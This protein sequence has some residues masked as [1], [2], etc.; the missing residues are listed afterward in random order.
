VPSTIDPYALIH[1][2][3]RHQLTTTLDRLASTDW[4]DPAARASALDDLDA[5]LRTQVLHAH[6]E[7]AFYH[8][9]LE[10]RAPGCTEKYGQ[11]HAALEARM[12]EIRTAAEAVGARGGPPTAAGA[13]GPEVHALYLQY[14]RVLGLLLSHFDDEEIEL[15]PVFGARCT[16]DDLRDLEG[17]VMAAGPPGSFETLLPHFLA[18]LSP[19]ELIGWL[20]GLQAG[21]A[22]EAFAGVCATAAALLDPSRWA[23]VGTALG[24]DAPGPTR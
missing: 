13:P 1:K 19:G 22:P 7:D 23:M 8:P 2:A 24:V 21:M 11:A 3:L 12:A 15:R 10:A 14:G 5:T 18:A 16:D 20:A 17:Q 6:H 4:S 9:L